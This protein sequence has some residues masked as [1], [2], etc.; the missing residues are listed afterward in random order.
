[1]NKVRNSKTVYRTILRPLLI[2]VLVEVVLMTGSYW[3]LGINN[4]LNKNARDILMQQTENRKSYLENEMIQKWS[5]LTTISQTIN[6]RTQKLIAQNEISLQTLDSSSKA[7]APLLNDISKELISTLYNKE[8]TGIFVVF[9]THDLR[10]NKGNKPGIYIRNEDPN[11]VSVKEYGDLLLEKAPIEVVQSL[12]I[13]TDVNWE[14]MFDLSTQE[15]T[16][17]YS[18]FQQAYHDKIKMEAKEYG[19]W[20]EN[21]YHLKNDD[22]SAISYSM[23]LILPDGTVYGVI[24][25]ELLTSYLEELMP[26]DELKNDHQGSYILSIKEKK[27]Q[28]SLVV[29]SSSLKRRQLKKFSLI[30]DKN[31]N[32][33]VFI[34]GKEYY[35]AVQNLN[36]YNSNGPFSNQQWQLISLVERSQLYT[37]SNHIFYLQI[38]MIVL[39]GIVT[40]IG[41]FYVSKKISGPIS[42]LSKEVTNSRQVKEIPELHATGIQEIDQFSSAI[43]ELSQEVLETSTKFLNI[44]NMASIDIGGYEIKKGSQNVYVTDNFFLLLGIDKVSLP[45]TYEQFEELFKEVESN[46]QVEIENENQRIYCIKKYAGLR[47]V[48]LKTR[49][50]GN[51]EIGIAEDI[52]TGYLERKRIEHERDFDVLTGLYNRFS[53]QRHMDYLFEHAEQLKIAALVMIDLDNLKKINDGFGHDWGDNY[54]RQCGKCF[55]E[56]V[57]DNTICA[58]VSGDEFYLFL[59]GYDSQEEIRQRLISMTSIM[60]HR[61]VLLPNGDQMNLSAS[62]GVSW[63]PQDSTHFEFLKKYADFAMYQVKKSTKGGL[64]EF[65]KALYEDEKHDR[66]MRLEFYQLIEKEQLTYHFQPILSA[67]NGEVIAYEALMRSQLATLKNPEKI[68]KIAREENKLEDIER[69]CIFKSTETFDQ[70]RKNKLIKEDA[71]LFINSIASVS[72]NDEDRERFHHYFNHIQS[73]IVVEVTEEENMSEEALIRKK[74]TKGFSGMFALDDYGSGYN[75]EINL[76]NLNPKYIKIDLTIVRDVDKDFDKQQL[77]SNIVDYAHQRDA[78]I[79]AEGIETKEELIKILELGVDYLQGYYLSYPQSNPQEVSD[80]S[81]QTIENYWKKR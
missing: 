8:A 60:R 79:I 1:M 50:E 55:Q 4:Q 53:F 75:T 3:F 65:D 73:K 54:I 45:L 29:S 35:A 9:N 74:E 49:K 5:N 56:N 32:N 59:Y 69:I 19:Y 33:Y 61:K 16:F 14:S 24:G 58:R 17:I 46:Y 81:I 38:S 51:R 47:Y 23:P 6:E 22:G 20:N 43:T 11:T 70:L 72:L 21:I 67:K 34:D 63:Y 31:K 7:C 64:T 78:Y 40:L 52:T 76:L 48:R 26:S 25:V 68:L 57:P 28:S 15:N 41:I 71:L 77:V 44:M 2:V 66:Q 39:V 10:E 36:I 37:F 27:Q 12:N 62:I 30:E 18:P 42:R 13:S 80:E